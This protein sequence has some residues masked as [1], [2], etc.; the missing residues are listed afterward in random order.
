MIFCYSEFIPTGLKRQDI[1]VFQERYC[2]YSGWQALVK[3]QGVARRHAKA[4]NQAD[5]SL[6]PQ[7]CFGISVYMRTA[8]CLT[9]VF[10]FGTVFF[11]THSGWHF[12]VEVHQFAP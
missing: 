2:H 7:P 10:R 1:I 11:M 4:V 6:D 8:W 3:A 12:G 5:Y 9:Q